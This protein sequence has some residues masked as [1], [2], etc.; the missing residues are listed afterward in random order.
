MA[1]IFSKLFNGDNRR[2]AQLEK[3]ANN[4]DALGAEMANLSDDQLRNK[5]K[6]FKDRLAN[7]ET[8]NDLMVPAFAVCR[9]AAK[10]VIGEYPYK[11]QIMGAAVMQGGDIAEMKTGKGKL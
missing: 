8:L 1:G 3:I 6:E 2:L 9:E 11:V 10:R 7:G 5:T 4:V